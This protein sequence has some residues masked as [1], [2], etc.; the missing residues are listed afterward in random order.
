MTKRAA[1]LIFLFLASGACSSGAYSLGSDPQALDDAGN[2]AGAT[3]ADPPCGVGL[4]ACPSGSYCDFTDDACGGM[5]ANGAT[6]GICRTAPTSC[7]GSCTTVCGCDGLEY[8]NACVAERAGV[9]VAPA[10]WCA[11]SGRRCGA[12]LGAGCAPDEFCDFAEV[13]C[14][15]S[16]PG[17]CLVRPDIGA[18]PTSC[19]PICACDGTEYCTECHAHVAGYD[20][21]QTCQ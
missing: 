14:G 20:R 2:D 21:A 10:E 3:D 6:H 13:D 1:P 7:D 9:D 12:W 17:K 16:K 4:A 8:C 15:A 5:A 18:C 19:N 11:T